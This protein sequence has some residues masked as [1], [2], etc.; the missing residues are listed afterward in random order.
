[1]SPDPMRGKPIVEG[2]HAVSAFN[3]LPEVNAAYEIPTPLGLIDSTIRKVIYTVGVRPTAADLLKICELLDELGVGEESLNVWYRNGGANPQEMAAARTVAGG[4]FKFKI[5]VFTDTLLG[6]G[7]QSMPQMRE[8]VDT[9]GEMGIKLLN[10]GLLQ[11]PNADA[12]Q[13]QTEQMHEMAEY[14]RA[15]GMEW[16]ATV[17]NC[18]RRDFDAFVDLSNRAIEAGVRR[19]DLM[20]STSA[21]S[22]QAMTYFVR[23]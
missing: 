18:G 11:P 20:D 10:P 5:N 23:T 2:R 19:F 6:D 9:F 8:T 1:M 7:T 21:L 3:F 15:A 17:A 16:N 22:P 4:G 13:R 14:V 12:R